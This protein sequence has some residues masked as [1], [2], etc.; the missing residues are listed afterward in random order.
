M[1]GGPDLERLALLVPFVASARPREF[2]TMKGTLVLIEAGHPRQREPR[3]ARPNRSLGYER[4]VKPR[5]DPA[6][7]RVRVARASF[8]SRVGF[9]YARLST[10]EEGTGVEWALL[11]GLSEE[12]V[13]HVLRLARRRRF[14][15]REVVWHEGDRAEAI[16]LIRSGRI[17]I[18]VLTALGEVA[19]VGVLGPGEAA[20]LIA[21]HGTDPFHTT[22]AVAL[23]PTETTAIR[24]DDFIELRR[25]LPAIDAALLGFL[26]DRV[27]DLTSQLIDALYAP[28]ESRVLRRLVAL[29]KLYDKGDGQIVI[30]LTQEDLAGLAGVTRPTVNRVLKKEERRGTLL[31]SRGSITITDADGLANRTS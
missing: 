26:A 17:A 12:E 2:G 6:P 19:T 25:R 16:H 7:A 3:P 13:E 23:E 15:R 28:A 22:S 29:A 1:E 14:A 24:V 5:T 10:Q 31:L 21:V 11:R 18:R 9:V 20:G 8:L 27:L 30:P 4:R